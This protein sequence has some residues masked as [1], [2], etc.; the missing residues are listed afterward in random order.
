MELIMNT[1]TQSTSS[2]LSLV[3]SSKVP[4][5]KTLAF[6]AAVASVFAG[7]FGGLSL[8][9]AVFGLVA[10]AAVINTYISGMMYAESLGGYGWTFLAYLLALVVTA[11]A[12]GQLSRFAKRQKSLISFYYE[13]IVGEGVVVAVIKQNFNRTFVLVSV[14]AEGKNRA[15]ET[16]DNYVPIEA[17]EWRDD[18]YVVGQTYEF[19]PST[20]V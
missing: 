3:D 12:Y 10:S 6:R 1:A 2:E 20:V 16:V 13:K 15:G 9:L 7:I 4:S 14:L 17:A 18:S 8:V 5:K 11:V 19:G